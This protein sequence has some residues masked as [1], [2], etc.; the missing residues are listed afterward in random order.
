MSLA[1]IGYIHSP[2]WTVNFLDKNDTTRPNGLRLNGNRSFSISVEKGRFSSERVSLRQ[3][4]DNFPT[5]PVRRHRLESVHDVL[6]KFRKR[7][8]RSTGRRPV[9][10]LKQPLVRGF[11]F[12]FVTSSRVRVRRDQSLFSSRA[13]N[14]CR[15]NASVFQLNTI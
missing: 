15:K 5:A 12:Y 1:Q 14:V 4:P 11:F 7:F 2:N 13:R 3:R 6:T 10:T 8:S 9:K